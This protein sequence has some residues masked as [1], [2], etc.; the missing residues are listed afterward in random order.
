MGWVYY[1]KGLASLAVSAFQ[2]SVHQNATNPTAHYHL[3]L[4]YLKDGNPKEGR[5]ALEQPLKLNP[6]L[7]DAEGARKALATLKG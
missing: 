5:K 2:Q 6:Q 7:P 3:G 4:V 1:K